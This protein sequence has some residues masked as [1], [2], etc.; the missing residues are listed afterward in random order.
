MPTQALSPWRERPE[1]YEEISK[2]LQKKFQTSSEITLSV[3]QVEKVFFRALQLHHLFPTSS[4]QVVGTFQSDIPADY[5]HFNALLI[6]LSPDLSTYRSL[7]A[8]E[9]DTQD[10]KSTFKQK[11]N[12]INTLL[13]MKKIGGIPNLPSMAEAFY[14]HKSLCSDFDELD[15]T[16]FD[17]VAYYRKETL[18]QDLQ[19][20]VNEKY[21]QTKV[22]N[23]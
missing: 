11:E 13:E 8:I 4:F 23:P 1:N 19:T 6:Q 10:Q 22:E 16:L 18:F 9:E 5:V 2:K 7:S 20:C 12:Q 15:P 14:S 17:P 3:N 21:I